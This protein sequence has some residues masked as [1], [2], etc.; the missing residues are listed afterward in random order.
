[1]LSEMGSDCE[2]GGRNFGEQ[3]IDSEETRENEEKLIQGK[4]NRM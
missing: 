1:M 3:G 4:K 2:R